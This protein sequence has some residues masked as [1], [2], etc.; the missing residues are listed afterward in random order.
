MF[1]IHDDYGRQFV[2][3]VS[4]IDLDPKSFDKIL[5]Y[6]EEDNKVVSKFIQ[7]TAEHSD[8][9]TIDGGN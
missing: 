1:R 5:F 9:M 8:W 3:R 2:C 7:R 6:S 4:I